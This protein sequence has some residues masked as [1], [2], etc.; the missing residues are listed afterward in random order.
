MVSIGCCVNRRGNCIGHTVRARGHWVLHYYA[1]HRY[2]ASKGEKFCL[3]GFILNFTA[4]DLNS[5]IHECLSFRK[6]Y[7]Y[8]YIIIIFS[9]ETVIGCLCLKSEKIASSGPRAMRLKASFFGC[10]QF[11]TRTWN[12]Y[13]KRF[14]LTTFFYLVCVLFLEILL[15]VLDKIFIWYG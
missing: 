14:L 12:I 5:Y 3:Y 6:Y 9:E 11:S 1:R 15:I 13:F 10:K 8:E 4:L 7:L 2:E